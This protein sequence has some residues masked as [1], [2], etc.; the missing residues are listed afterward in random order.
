MFDAG[1]KPAEAVVVVFLVFGQLVVLGFL[2]GDLD[3]GMLVL[4][5]LIAAVGLGA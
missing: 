2:V 5:S 4:Q 1:A 3:V